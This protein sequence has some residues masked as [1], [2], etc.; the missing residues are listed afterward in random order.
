MREIRRLVIDGVPHPDIWQRLGISKK[1]FY[2]Y[3]NAV[4]DYDTR[5]MKER[6]ND[7][8]IARQMVVLRERFNKMY[9]ETEAMSNDESLDGNLRLEARK[10]A[11]EFA[12][13][14]KQSPCS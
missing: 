6:T 10:L 9:Q 14:K 11:C 12:L 8:E 2:R 7:E 13:N 5:V 4:F 1:S 3:L